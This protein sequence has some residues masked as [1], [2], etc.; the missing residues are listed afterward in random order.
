MSFYPSIW[1]E[2]LAMKIDFHIRDAAAN[3]D[4]VARV[5]ECTR[6][7]GIA[8]GMSELGCDVRICGARPEFIKSN[9]WKYFVRMSGEPRPGAISVRPAEVNRSAD[10]LIKTS[11]TRRNDVERIKKCDVYVAREYPE[12]LNRSPKLCPVPF[13]VHDRIWNDW[14]NGPTAVM[15]HYLNDDIDKLRMH[16]TATEDRINKIAFAGVEHYGR[17]VILAG[18]RKEFGRDCDFIT[19]DSPGMGGEEYLQ[20][21]ATH[22][23]MLCPPGDTPKTNRW[24]E[25]ALLGVAIIS[26]EQETKVYPPQSGANTVYLQDWTDFDA[27]THAMETSSKQS[28]G[29]Y[30]DLIEAATIHYQEGWSLKGQARQILL[31]LG[32]S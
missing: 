13:P 26:T 6:M 15:W 7:S 19:P 2:N 31:R 21:L 11:V 32:E 8:Y 16:Y 17:D 27:V 5:R 9:R 28:R 4:E 10:V 1:K 29:E 23:A 25:A 3:N 24:S 12:Q 18:F 20:W 30:S 14:C 22:R